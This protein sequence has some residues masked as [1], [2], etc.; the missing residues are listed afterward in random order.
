MRPLSFEVPELFIELANA[1]DVTGGMK[2][3]DECFLMF[4]KEP[5]SITFVIL[6][7]L[8]EAAVEEKHD[9]HASY[10]TLLLKHL[11]IVYS[12]YTRLN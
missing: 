2:L 10:F 8:R 6:D 12:E 3:V 7:G 11:E 1:S 4:P 5:D 9:K